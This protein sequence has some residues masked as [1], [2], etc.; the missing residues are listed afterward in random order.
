MYPRVRRRAKAGFNAAA[1]EGREVE[2]T[3]DSPGLA[4]D[5]SKSR[6]DFSARADRRDN[7]VPGCKDRPRTVADFGCSTPARRAWMNRLLPTVL[8]V[9]R[10][11]CPVS[12]ERVA[13]G[14]SNNVALC[15]RGR[16][17]FV[18]Y[19]RSAEKLNE[20]RPGNS[21]PA[22]EVAEDD[23]SATRPLER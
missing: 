10:K 17:A 11:S 16:G 23:E 12:D 8:L 15:E 20:L 3:A 6:S 14:P 7:G 5:A 18:R 4:V 19:G 1:L 13:E 2:L 21:R 22:I 9:R